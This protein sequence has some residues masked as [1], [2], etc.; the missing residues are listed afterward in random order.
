MF[1]KKA[2]EYV[3]RNKQKT[4]WKFNYLIFWS[5]VVNITDLVLTMATLLSKRAFDDKNK[6]LWFQQDGATFYFSNETIEWLKE[7]VILTGHQDHGWT[8]FFGAT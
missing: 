2:K 3:N 5:H 7:M 1:C 4:N 8:D 6:M